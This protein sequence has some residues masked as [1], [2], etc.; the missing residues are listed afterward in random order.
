MYCSPPPNT[1]RDQRVH[2]LGY[3]STNRLET[4]QPGHVTTKRPQISN[5]A[6]YAFKETRDLILSEIYQQTDQV[7]HIMGYTPEHFRDHIQLQLD[8]RS[9]ILQQILTR[10]SETRHTMK[11]TQK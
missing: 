9:Q 6:V 11:K 3:T 5:P 4:S 1:Q 2:T 10:T 7:T 8:Q